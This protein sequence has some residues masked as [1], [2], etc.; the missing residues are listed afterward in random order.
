MELRLHKQA[1]LFEYFINFSIKSRRYF[2]NQSEL[3]K[4][5]G[6]KWGIVVHFS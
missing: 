2:N 4:K 6:G 3:L 1:V 5:G